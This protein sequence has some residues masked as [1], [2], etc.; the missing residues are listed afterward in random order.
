MKHNK[1]EQKSSRESATE[2]E[3]EGEG[4]GSDRAFSLWA[5]GDGRARCRGHT[6][7]Q[8][9][10]NRWETAAELQRE[11]S[12]SQT[13][14]AGA[15]RAKRRGWALKMGAVLQSLLLC[16]LCLQIRGEF[17]LFARNRVDLRRL[18]IESLGIARVVFFGA[19]LDAK[20]SFIVGETQLVCLLMC[21]AFIWFPSSLCGRLNV[22]ST[23]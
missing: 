4:F 20:L 18:R 22:V 6:E 7:T 14:A 11:E 8:K 5:E 10:S 9:Q 16:T 19:S 23:G 2:G 1:S 17:H 3:G 21:N 15:M 13:R 12:E